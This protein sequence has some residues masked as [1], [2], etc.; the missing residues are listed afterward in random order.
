MILAG[1]FLFIV[2]AMIFSAPD[3]RADAIVKQV[4][5]RYDQSKTI[6]ADFH[7]TFHWVL[8][9]TKSE[10]NGTIWL[11]DKEKFKIKTETQLVVSDGKTIW[12]YSQSTNQVLI[13]NVQKAEDIT[14][15]RDIL[16]NFSDKY[17]ATFVKE[18][19]LNGEDCF[20][21]ELNSKTDDNFIKKMT[22]WVSQKRL[23]VKK[24]VQT[25]LNNNLNTYILS[26]IQFDVLLEDN[27]F[28]Y[29]IPDSV[30]VIDM[31]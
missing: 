6:K 28:K 5:N 1:F 24:I 18:E 14:L 2:P 20:V 29:N 11:E 4:L 22:I 16:L 27:F 30:E 3:T 23:V 13:D 12:T 10:Q 7:Q 25:D 21:I 17:Q 15:P 9:N 31:R 26:N 8:T 19:K